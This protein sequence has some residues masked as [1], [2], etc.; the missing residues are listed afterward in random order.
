[1]SKPSTVA[2]PSAAEKGGSGVYPD[3][4]SPNRSQ[5]EEGQAERCGQAVL[6]GNGGLVVFPDY[7]T[8]QH[9]RAQKEAK[10][11]GQAER[12]GERIRG[13]PPSTLIYLARIPKKAKPSAAAEPSAAEKGS[14]GVSRDYLF[15]TI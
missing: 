8:T 13:K 7:D 5:A 10:R 9:A 11:I 6:S 14:L 3:Y 1:M 12:S 15:V 2:R 4:D